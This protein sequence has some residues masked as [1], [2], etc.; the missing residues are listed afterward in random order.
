[1]PEYR[2]SFRVVIKVN[3]C[4]ISVI[5]QYNAH[6]STWIIPRS[7]PNLTIYC[8]NKDFPSTPNLPTQRLCNTIMTGSRILLISKSISR[9]NL[10]WMQ[11]I[12]II[13]YAALHISCALIELCSGKE[14]WWQ[15]YCYMIGSSLL[16]SESQVNSGRIFTSLFL[17]KFHC[18][19]TNGR[20]TRTII[21][22]FEISRQNYLN[23]NF[24]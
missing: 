8:W 18:H 14:L 13:L 11:L 9:S 20:H 22:M 15:L 24:N 5:D 7:I 16:P 1:M 19:T 4:M 3:A 23:N 17:T 10:S 21:K 12:I 2:K 6:C